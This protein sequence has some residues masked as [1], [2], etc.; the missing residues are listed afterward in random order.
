MFSCLLAGFL[1]PRY[2]CTVNGFESTLA[3]NHFGHF[4][5]TMH[6]RPLLRKTVQDHYGVVMQQQQQ[7]Q[8]QH[9]EIAMQ[10]GDFIPGRVVV[11]AS[12]AHQR[13]RHAFDWHPFEEMLSDLSPC[14][15]CPSPAEQARRRR[16]YSQAG[17]RT[18]S[19]SKLCNI[20]FT[21]ELARR[22][23]LLTALAVVCEVLLSDSQ[24][25]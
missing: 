25:C 21:Q 19:L 9:H 6:L 12:A 17:W 23:P 10:Q 7:R 24:S 8:Q 1:S 3:C 5:L 22:E 13:I 11:V 20:L 18:Y 4:A 15:S 14:S 2:H 16:S